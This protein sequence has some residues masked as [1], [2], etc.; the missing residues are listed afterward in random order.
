MSVG[1]GAYD[2]EIDATG[3]GALLSMSVLPSVTD[4]RR[5]VQVQRAAR[6]MAAG[7]GPYPLPHSPSSTPQSHSPSPYQLRSRE[8][9]NTNLKGH[10]LVLSAELQKRD[11]VSASGHVRPLGRSPSYPPS[12]Y[13]PSNEPGASPSNSQASLSRDANLSQGSAR[14][15]PVS[16]SRSTPD[17]SAEFSSS[18]L[19]ARVASM[20][21]QLVEAQVSSLRDRC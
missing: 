3:C 17:H 21:Q 18:E 16:F 9:E 8:D 20:Q 15:T 6:S 13:T 11:G 2:D 5:R 12:T 14:G 7:A 4:T 1:G 19:L 10:L